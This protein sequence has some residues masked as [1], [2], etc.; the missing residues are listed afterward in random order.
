[1]TSTRTPSVFETVTPEVPADLTPA[2][3]RIEAT[4]LHQRAANINAAH[5]SYLLADYY[6]RTADAYRA[7]AG[8]LEA[9]TA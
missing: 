8:A 1:M 6:A 9:V 5:G 4:R 7:A 2:Q 3:L